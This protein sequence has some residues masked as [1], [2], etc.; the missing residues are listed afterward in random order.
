MERCLVKPQLSLE[1]VFAG[2]QGE[3]LQVGLVPGGKQGLC[4]EP[5]AG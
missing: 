4:L 2:L 3:G 1:A 5:L